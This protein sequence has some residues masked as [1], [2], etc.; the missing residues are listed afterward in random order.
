MDD[1]YRLALEVPSISD[2]L[3]L[4]VAAGLSARSEAAAAAGLPGTIA[5]ATVFHEGRAI[6][7]GR[8]T[9]D[10]GLF[11]Q[12]VDMAV[13]PPHQRRGL[14]KAIMAALME[15]LKKTVPAEAYVSLIADG[16]ASELYSQFGF[17]PT[18]PASCG[19]AMWI[20]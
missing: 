3:R 7:M 5:A 11:F 8:V 12:I 14:G 20:R 10:G 6:G 2:Y 17:R 18:A 13:E 4:R 16:H 1:A 19:M 15:T 9:G